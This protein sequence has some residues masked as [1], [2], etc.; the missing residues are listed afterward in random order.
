MN[1]TL[2]NV[3]KKLQNSDKYIAL[4]EKAFVTKK[5]TGQL[6]LK[7]ISQFIVSLMYDLVRYETRKL[8]Y[9]KIS[10]LNLIRSAASLFKCI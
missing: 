6:T 4:F 3:I 9:M 5:I 8:F 1:E 2:E 7:A 10:S